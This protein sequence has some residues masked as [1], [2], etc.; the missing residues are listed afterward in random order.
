[1]RRPTWGMTRVPAGISKATRSAR[2]SRFSRVPTVISVAPLGA[3]RQTKATILR[4]TPIQPSALGPCLGPAG[5]VA[6]QRDCSLNQNFYLDK[7][8]TTE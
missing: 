6:D 4:A 1:M 3:R 8:M 2:L 7:N 5:S